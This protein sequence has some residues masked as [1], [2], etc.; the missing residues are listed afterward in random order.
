MCPL[1]A[2]AATAA[3]DGYHNMPCRSSLPAL[4]SQANFISLSNPVTS[5]NAPP[6]PPLQLQPAFALRSAP[7]SP[8]LQQRPS[9]AGH[10]TASA[11]LQALLHQWTSEHEA[12]PHGP[13]PTNPDGDPYMG[14]PVFPELLSD[15][16]AELGGQSSSADF[17]SNDEHVQ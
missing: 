10:A 6:A 7:V 16:E 4:S 14:S 5:V 1:Q 11:P 13:L 15:I 12:V 2:I 8:S 9:S 3:S 17:H